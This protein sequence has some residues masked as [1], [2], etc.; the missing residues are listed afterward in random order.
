MKKSSVSHE[1]AVLGETLRQARE[2][3]GVTQV[4]LAARLK[5]TQSYVSKLERGAVRLDFVQV[6]RICLALGV[7]FTA[8]AKEFEHSLSERGKGR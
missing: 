6:R 7:G 1:Y 3:A 5:Q 4:E 2:K 8:L